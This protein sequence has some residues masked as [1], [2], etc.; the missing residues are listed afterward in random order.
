M[1]TLLQDLRYG[2]RMLAK[3][4]GFTAAAAVTL[5]LGIGANTAM[6]SVVNAALLR[7]LP[8]ENPDR[9]VYVWSAEKARGINQSTVSIP[10]L[11]DWRGQ[12]RVQR[13]SRCPLHEGNRASEARRNN[14]ARSSGHGHDRS[15]PGA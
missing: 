11:H 6:F 5:A 8:Y 15:P 10:D 2:F 3:N 4:P 7:S 13:S 9:L 1:S 14:R 12:N